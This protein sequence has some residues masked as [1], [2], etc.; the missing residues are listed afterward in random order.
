VTQEI[1]ETLMQNSIGV[2]R[3]FFDTTGKMSVTV[4]DYRLFEN[5]TQRVEVM[6]VNILALCCLI[7]LNERRDVMEKWGITLL[8]EQKVVNGFSAAAE[9]VLRKISGAE[10][11]FNLIAQYVEE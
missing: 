1:N 9:T 3:V 6:R 10:Q 2:I 8:S 11:V 4:K 7:Q 5:G